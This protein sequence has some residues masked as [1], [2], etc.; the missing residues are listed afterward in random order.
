MT[1]EEIWKAIEL[2]AK[3]KNTSVSG[4]ARLGG[5]DPTTFNRSKRLTSDGQQRWPSTQSLAKVLSA[6]KTSLDEFAKYIPASGN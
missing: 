2:F 4:L 6:T 1:H 3:D 5:L